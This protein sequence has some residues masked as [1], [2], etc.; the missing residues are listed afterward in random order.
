M[1]EMPL[2]TMRTV[3][4]MYV[5]IQAF[6]LVMFFGVAPF[7]GLKILPPEAMSIVQLVLP[8]FTGYIG[9]ILGHYFGSRAK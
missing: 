4:T 6:V 9:L 1:R 5:T 2:V 7:V 8:L 3:L